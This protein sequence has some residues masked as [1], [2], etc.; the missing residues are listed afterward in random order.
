M[1]LPSI[2]QQYQLIREAS[3]NSS[4]SYNKFINWVSG[5]FDLQLQDELNGLQIFFPNGK[6]NINKTTCTDNNIVAEINFESNIQHQGNE[7]INQ[8]MAI[9]NQLINS[10]NKTIVL[11]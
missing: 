1:K 10:N 5:E 9:Y 7:I 11:V 3:F 4:S 6:L 8:I 2:M